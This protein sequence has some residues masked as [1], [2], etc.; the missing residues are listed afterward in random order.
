MKY[1]IPNHL[2]VYF[3]SEALK[4]KDESGHVETLAYLLGQIGEDCVIAEELVF[5]NQHCFPSNVKDNGKCISVS[6]CFVSI[7][8]LNI[9]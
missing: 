2:L 5:P 4:N 1:K 3:E 9:I 6:C 7:S 8:C